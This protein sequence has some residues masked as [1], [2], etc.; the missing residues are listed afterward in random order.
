[1]RIAPHLVPETQTALDK[2]LSSG[3]R[4]YPQYVPVCG[5]P[6]DCLVQW[7][8][9]IV[10]ANPFF[11]AFPRGTFIRGDGETIEEAER[12]AFAQYEREIACKH[13]FGR[14]HPRR[15]TYTNGGAFCH[16]C[17]RFEGSHFQ[18]VFQFGEHRKPL[19]LWEAAWL[20]ELETDHEMNA[21]MDAKYP[22][23]K[24]RRIKSAKLMRIRKKL[25]GV[26]ENSSRSSFLG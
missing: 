20:N 22:E 10:P 19:K 9:G 26:D 25:F 8:N 2:A 6:E 7:G 13:F 12:K 16:R 24:Q 23:Q 3:S 21:H 5:W 17:G 1:M 4:L 14:H 18:P 15:G 11:E